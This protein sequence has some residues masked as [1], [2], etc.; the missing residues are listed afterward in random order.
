[1]IGFGGKGDIKWGK[2][3]RFGEWKITL[4]ILLNNKGKTQDAETHFETFQQIQVPNQKREIM[5]FSFVKAMP[6]T[7]RMHQIRKHCNLEGFPIIGDRIYGYHKANKFFIKEWGINDM[8]LHS[9][10]YTIIHPVTK[11]PLTLE[12]DIRDAFQDALNKLKPYY[13][14]IQR[15]L[16]PKA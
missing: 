3:I 10:S 13:S 9:K 5:G 7:G 8:L 1:M 6:T 14:D 11:E 16:I 12:A 2:V 15:D 4:Y